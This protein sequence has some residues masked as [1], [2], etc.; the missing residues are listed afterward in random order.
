MKRVF[1]LSDY[2]TGGPL[3]NGKLSKAYNDMSAAGV[4]GAMTVNP[5]QNPTFYGSA[6]S[7]MGCLFTLHKDDQSISLSKRAEVFTAREV[8]YADKFNTIE[9][10]TIFPGSYPNDT[11]PELFFQLAGNDY[12]LF[13]PNLALWIVNGQFRLNMKYT[14]AAGK[15]I[16]KGFSFSLPFIRRSPIR[17]MIGFKKGIDGSGLVTLSANGVQRLRVPGQ[18]CNIINGLPEQ[19][20]FVKFGVYKWPWQSGRVTPGITQRQ[21]FFSDIVI[22]NI[23]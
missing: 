18:N 1:F 8:D 16:E 3:Q 17:W 13:N 2:T 12:N 11:Q 15:N 19:R 22:S 9:F 7:K 10:T 4:P 14:D 6:F 21:I 5:L 23:S 20:H